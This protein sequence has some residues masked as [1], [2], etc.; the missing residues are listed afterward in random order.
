MNN[1]KKNVF[2][3]SD[4]I[5]SPLG[6]T[7]EKNFI[8]LKKGNSGI[9]LHSNV[10]LWSTPFY[11]SLFDNSIDDKLN[12]PFVTNS[13]SS[14]EK[15]LVESVNIASQNC[16]V[17]VSSSKTIFI[18]STTKGNI[19]LLENE[20]KDWPYAEKISLHHS[21][22]KV[23]GY[24]KNTNQPIVI[25]NACISGVLAIITAMRL[26]QS[27]VYE[28]AVVTGADL[29]TKFILSG[30]Y[31]FQAISDEACKPFDKFR[32]GL[33]LGEA[34]GTIILS[35]H[36]ENNNS[37]SVRVTAGAITNDANHISGPSRTGEE[38]S[39]AIN[40]T[41]NDANISKG[42][43]DFMSLHGTA[44]VYN[45]EME[46]KAISLSGLNNVLANSLKGYF[47]HTLGAAGI[48]ESVISIYSMKN[49]LMIPTIG[50]NEIGVSKTVNICSSLQELP[51]NHCLKTASGFG[52]CNAA[53][54]FSKN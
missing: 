41:L 7:S 5:I 1:M 50:F 37:D 30:F 9:G 14:F 47:G 10:E 18:I 49:N 46:A 8:Q 29:I 2:I 33:T 22:K 13:F 12:A 20:G 27:G 43:L 39:Y 31:S 52:G 51:L 42:M 38:L 16:S 36:E 35:A 28:N 26:I 32:T 4:N 45:D 23:S 53:V 34:A 11:A 6:F 24:F 19:G 17:N 15:L 25:S 3:V 40:K 54:L 48:I 44:T 21:A